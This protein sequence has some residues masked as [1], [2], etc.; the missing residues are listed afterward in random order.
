MTLPLISTTQS[1]TFLLCNCKFVMRHSLP[2]HLKRNTS[3]TNNFLAAPNIYTNQLN[4]WCRYHNHILSV[5][6]EPKWQVT[7]LCTGDIRAW[8]TILRLVSQKFAERLMELSLDIRATLLVVI[9]WS[10]HFQNQL[11]A[12]L[13]QRS[14]LQYQRRPWREKGGVRSYFFLDSYSINQYVD[15]DTRRDYGRN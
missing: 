10:T 9:K 1:W 14:P 4:Y 12:T 7:Q 2:C 11:D 15:G 5:K 13:T 6:L 3:S 8:Q